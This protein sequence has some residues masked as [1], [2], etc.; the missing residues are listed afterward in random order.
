MPSAVVPSLLL[1]GPQTGL[2][3]PEQLGQLRATLLAEPRLE[4]FRTA[5]E[6]LPQFW[7]TLVEF[8]PALDAVPG[9]EA[10]NS[11][12][13]WLDRGSIE[14]HSE[15][16]PPNVLCT[17]FTVIFHLV[18]YFQYLRENELSFT[19][20]SLLEH[21][22]VGSIEGFCAG[23]LAA[24]AIACSKTE[25]DVSIFG[26][27]AL[28]LGLCIAAYVDLEG[29]FAKASKETTCFTV[30]WK[31]DAMKAK[32]LETLKKYPEVS[33]YSTLGVLDVCLH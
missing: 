9:L 12:R 17:S 3:S 8:D 31:S 23:F 22:K 20:E 18:L 30:R 6:E 24:T 26:S 33:N 32:G 10:V 1:F 5:I 15:E 25:E 7:R 28:R 21:L 2:P 16:I 11:I 4:T 27:V 13:Q 14:N 19:H 29:R